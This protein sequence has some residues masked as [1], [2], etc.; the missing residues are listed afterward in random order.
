MLWYGLDTIGS[1]TTCSWSVDNNLAQT[2]VLKGHGTDF[3]ETLPNQK[4]FE[5]TQYSM[6][7]HKLTVVYNGNSSTTPLTVDYLIIQNGTLSSS[8]SKATSTDSSSLAANPTTKIGLTIF[9]VVAGAACLLI[10][11][12]SIFFGQRRRDSANARTSLS[13]PSIEGDEQPLDTHVSNFGEPVLVSQGVRVASQVPPASYSMI[14]A[15]AITINDG[16]FN[17]FIAE[18]DKVDEKRIY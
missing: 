18:G 14:T 6:G 7:S 15:N 17:Q 13:N 9:G 2:F 1:S 16:I 4:F 5:T 12:L 11:L 10:V 3:N 8:S